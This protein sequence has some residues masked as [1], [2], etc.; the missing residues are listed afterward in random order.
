MATAE[1]AQAAGADAESPSLLLPLPQAAP[2]ASGSARKESWFTPFQL[3]RCQPPRDTT[4]TSAG[5]HGEAGQQEA[6]QG[7]RQAARW[8]AG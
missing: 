6:G 3:C 4:A 7:M 1:E 2:A 5:G 8:W